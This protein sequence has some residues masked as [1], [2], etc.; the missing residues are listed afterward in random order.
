MKRIKTLCANPVLFLFA[1]II[2]FA[3]TKEEEASLTERLAEND[4]RKMQ[5][6]ISADSILDTIPTL[7]VIN[8]DCKKDNFWRFSAVSNTF[9]LLE[10]PTKCSPSDPDIK[11][12]GVIEE[13]NNGTQL[14]VSGGGTEEIWEIE[15][16]S[17]SS[18]RV[19]YFARTGANKLAKFRV[20]FD[21]I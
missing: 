4:W 2:T 1:L 15:S 20:R 14:R 8:D 6:L 17:A 3:C 12:Q 9:Q 13:L 18:F 21:K 16:L 7:E 5:I 11:D 10:G 19:S